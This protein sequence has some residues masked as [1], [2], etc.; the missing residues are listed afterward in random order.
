MLVDLPK[1]LIQEITKYAKEQD[2]SVD[3]FILWAIAEK[4]G[5]LKHELMASNKNPPEK[6]L[7]S[8]KTTK[9]EYI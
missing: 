7:T 5:E 3:S 2:T 6:R 8:E 1:G 4:V 9:D